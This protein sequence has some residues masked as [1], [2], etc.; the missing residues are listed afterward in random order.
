MKDTIDIYTVG[1]DP[2][3]YNGGIALLKNGKL[4][5]K[6]ILPHIKK[7]EIDKKEFKKILK[8]LV[9]KEPTVFVEQVHALYGVSAAATASFMKAFGEIIS[10]IEILDLRRI[11]VK[12]KPWQDVMFQG[13]PELRKAL[14]KAEKGKGKKQG[15][16]DTKAMALIAS[17]RLFPK[18]NFIPEGCRVPND[19]LVDA[20][21]IGLYGYWSLIGKVDDEKKVKKSGKR[22]LKK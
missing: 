21:L 17:N 2:G 3:L 14:T 11:E 13:V 15:K 8:K 16:K 5:K 18:T 19:G 6:W 22:K 7:K 20:A 12:P 4:I 10:A 9:K 1:I